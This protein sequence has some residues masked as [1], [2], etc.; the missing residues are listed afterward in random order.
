MQRAK[1]VSCKD[2]QP[3][4]HVPQ[5][6]RDGTDFMCEPC[7]KRSPDW[8]SHYYLEPPSCVGAGEVSFW[9]S[10]CKEWSVSPKEYCISCD[11]CCKG[12]CG[13]CAI[14]H[15]A[16]LPPRALCGSCSTAVSRY[17]LQVWIAFHSRKRFEQAS[18]ARCTSRTGVLKAELV[19]K[20]HARAERV[21]AVAAAN[22]MKE[23]LDSLHKVLK[24]HLQIKKAEAGVA[25]LHRE[26][27][28]ATQ[29][30]YCLPVPS[31]LLL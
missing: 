20:Y 24:L 28:N 29:N 26:L 17:G 31:S 25:A 9:C 12:L 1:C 16:T 10:D 14:L 18:K 21:R 5:L 2:V 8:S 19:Q 7:L 23:K 3:C 27:D 6:T 15:E 4:Y 11:A 22:A 30:V 13:D